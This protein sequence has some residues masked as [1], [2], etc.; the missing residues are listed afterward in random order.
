MEMKVLWAGAL[1]I[2]GWLWFILFVRQFIFNFI[3]HLLI[4]CS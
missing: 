3:K 4:L 1:F 2:A